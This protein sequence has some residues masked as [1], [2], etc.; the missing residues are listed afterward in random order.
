MGMEDYIRK[1][2]Y[3]QVKKKKGFY[4]HLAVF[5]SVG[6]FFFLINILSM[7]SGDTELWFFFPLL[8]WSIGLLIHYFS[9]FG[10]PG[11]NILTKDWEDTEIEKEMQKLRQKMR[12]YSE[13][14]S[15]EKMELRELDKEKVKQNRN[16]SDDEIV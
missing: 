13:S 16:W 11:T 2:A 1:R 9:V 4:S 15:N 8:P 6:I 7:S 5:I 12:Q 14:E 10:L 3:Q